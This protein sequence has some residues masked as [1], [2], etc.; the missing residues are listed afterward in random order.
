MSAPSGTVTF[1]FT[2]LEGSTELWQSVP[3]AMEKALEQHD[4]LLRTVIDR[5]DGY[6]FTTA[7]DSFA[8]A[9]AR[10]D[11]AVRCAVEIQRAVSETAWPA[12]AVL[13]IRMGLHAGEAQERDGDYFGPAVNL[14][15]RVMVLAA[16]GQVLVSAAVKAVLADSLRQELTLRDLGQ[17]ELKGIGEPERLFQV[18]ADGL[19][20]S[21]PALPSVAA[22]GNLPVQ[23]ESLIGRDRDLELVRRILEESRL[24]TIVGVGGIG[25]TR[26]ALGTASTL[27][28]RWGDGVWL[29]ELA[30]IGDGASLPQAV[31]DA[32]GC[33]QHVGRTLTE[34][35]AEFFRRRTALLVLDNCEHVLD[36]AAE[37]VDA[38]L[39]AAPGVQVLATSR[40]ALG[41][42]SEHSYPL[43][44][45][46]TGGPD[47][48][49]EVLFIRRAEQVAPQRVWEADQLDA[50]NQICERLDGIP[51]AIELAASR[52]RSMTPVDIAGRLD[53]AFLDLRG[54][55]RSVERHRTLKAAIDW[56]HDALDDG[57]R[58]VFA[59][60]SVF[61]GG[62]DL[63]AAEAVAVGDDV[64]PPDVF[65]LVD[66]LVSR[67]L[68]VASAGAGGATRFRMLEPVR[69][70]AEDQLAQRGESASTRNA[71]LAWAVAWAET[72]ARQLPIDDTGWR[73]ALDENIPNLRSAV[74]WACQNHRADETLSILED[75][76]PAIQFL[77]RLELGRWAELALELPEVQQHPRAAVAYSV[78][79][80]G[81][82]WRGDMESAQ[83]LGAANVKASLADPTMLYPAASASVAIYLQGDYRQAVEHLRRGETRTDAEAAIQ[84]YLLCNHLQRA[85]FENPDEP[86]LGLID[87]SLNALQ[88]MADRTQSA[89][90]LAIYYNQTGEQA[91]NS[92][93]VMDGTKR[94]RQ[95]LEA[96]SRIGLTLFV[97]FGATHFARAAN[98]IGVIRP[99]NASVTATG[100]R[101]MHDSGQNLDQWLI[102]GPL[103]YP[104]WRLGYRE[105]AIATRQGYM[106]TPFNPALPAAINEFDERAEFERE[107][108]SSIIDM[109]QEGLV[110][111]VLVILDELAAEDEAEDRS[112]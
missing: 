15:A 28:D 78:A 60:L 57:E 49:G 43:P 61:A 53:T 103:A 27:S 70:Y 12:E 18:E 81:A 86:L 52:C 2:D 48:A 79:T 47:S 41:V 74:E 107:S 11:A 98:A 51:L 77:Q 102:L 25:K 50:I 19:A 16:G 109:S 66:S 3:A 6:V 40:E 65:D 56:S 4:A 39:V 30:P 44:S 71:H 110:D 29:V 106:S 97:G 91:L 95:T 14:A 112:G 20:V 38:V 45:L 67:S 33:R 111:A 22:V 89:L 5:F 62:W 85:I 93:A 8:V 10:A 90:P 68:V 35:V 26:L 9:F 87:E 13:R 69:Q 99:E 21:F 92:G 1:L 34:S 64:D 80:S 100:L 7:G 63:A 23:D 104:L 24:C 36:A 55:R 58:S 82:W 84:H 31:A 54:G 73:D 75:L 83:R 46:E 37:F 101:D 94:A 108:D 96:A 88:D 32:I 72:W 105:V 76:V 17:Q 42:R 59:R